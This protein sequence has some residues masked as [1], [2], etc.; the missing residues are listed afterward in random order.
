LLY[1]SRGPLLSIVLF[2]FLYLYQS[3]LS[4][5]IDKKTKTR[6]NILIITGILTF[7][8]LYFDGFKLIYQFLESRGFYSRTLY[9]FANDFG[10]LSNRDSIYNYFWE[11]IKS[12]PFTIRGIGA[13]R[14]ALNAYPHNF[15]IELLY[16]L[17]LVISIPLLVMLFIIS[18]KSIF[19]NNI[20]KYKLLI[21]A[22]FCVGMALRMISGSLWED[23][24][25]WAWIALITKYSNNTIDINN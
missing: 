23:M 17:G 5:N 12:S 4:K 3:V 13:D 25:F 18:I 16:Q 10:H 6:F 19:T 2:I 9:L 1:G 11:A 8:F 14:V 7:T 21:T 22:F 20:S 24:Y 15:I